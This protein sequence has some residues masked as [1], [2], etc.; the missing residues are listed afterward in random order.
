MRAVSGGLVTLGAGG[1]LTC[2]LTWAYASTQARHSWPIWPYGLCGGLFIFGL[3]FSGL[4]S[5]GQLSRRDQ[6]SVLF[7]RRGEPE[8]Q[9]AQPA[10][11]EEPAFTIEALVPAPRLKPPSSVSMA[12]VPEIWNSILVIAISNKSSSAKFFADAFGVDFSF[13]VGMAGGTWRIPWSDDPLGQPRRIG[14]METARLFLARRTTA[15]V[16]DSSHEDGLTFTGVGR[17]KAEWMV[18]GDVKKLRVRVTRSAGGDFIDTTF[19]V[20]AHEG[21]LIFRKIDGES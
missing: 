13:P 6:T 20:G 4:S 1:V 17:P 21:S 10:V 12:I 16:P 11:S 15:L 3:A 18:P 19:E 14:A 5:M 7:R 9:I 8:P 2:V